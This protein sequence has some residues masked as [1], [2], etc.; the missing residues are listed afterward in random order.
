MSYNMAKRMLLAEQRG[1]PEDQATCASSGRV[2]VSN[3][4]SLSA[5]R[6]TNGNVTNL[7]NGKYVGQCGRNT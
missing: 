5:T 1:K 6:S 4:H 2:T 7:G 3:L